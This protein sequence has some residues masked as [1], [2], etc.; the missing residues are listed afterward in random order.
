MDEDEDSNQDDEVED[1]DDIL[2]A[3]STEMDEGAK[4]MRIIIQNSCL[5]WFYNNK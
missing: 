2:A 5:N 3:A 1:I 4:Q